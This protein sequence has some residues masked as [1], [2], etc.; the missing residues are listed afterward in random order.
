MDGFAL[1]VGCL[2]FFGFDVNCLSDFVKATLLQAAIARD[3]R[4]NSQ[5]LPIRIEL[6]TRVQASGCP[7]RLNVKGSCEKDSS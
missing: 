7:V 1:S 4:G 5:L 3:V 6:D 2:D